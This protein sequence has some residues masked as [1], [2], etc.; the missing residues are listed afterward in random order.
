MPRGLCVYS[1]RGYTFRVRKC[2]VQ[3]YSNW[4]IRCGYCLW[5]MYIVHMHCEFAYCVYCVP[6]SAFLNAA[7]CAGLIVGAA[8]GTI[9]ALL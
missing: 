1:V 5:V 2:T 4:A 7:V 8:D 3:M 6:R 9:A